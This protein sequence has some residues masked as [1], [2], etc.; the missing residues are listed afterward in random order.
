MRYKHKYIVGST[1]AFYANLDDL[2]DNG[3]FGQWSF[4]L[5]HSDSY[6]IEYSGITTLT[7]DI[8]SGSDYR[9]YADDFV[10]PDVN[11]GCYRLIVHD[12]SNG[13]VLYM[14]DE[15]EVVDVYDG[16]SYVSY[17]NGIDILN[18]NYEGLTTFRNKFHVELLQ[19]KPLTPVVTEG[20]DLANGSFYRVRTIL[21]KTFEFV[22]GWF[23]EVEHDATQA[24]SI[25]SDVIAQ[26]DGQLKSVSLPDD[27]EYA[28]E[29]QEN[30]NFV[31]ASFRL[32]VDNR[33][34]SNKAI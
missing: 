5:I 24:M 18:Y 25:H 6:I 22:T 27:S 9:F 30:Y 10:F 31:E 20:Y 7:K 11:I 29:W 26:I 19:R 14:T 33:S 17:R 3:N 15:I 12:T 32:E 1:Y 34:S 8:I 16:L 23:D 13:N 28:L 4:D 21:T 2:E